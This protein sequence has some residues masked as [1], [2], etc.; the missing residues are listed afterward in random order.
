MIDEWGAL[1]AWRL[2]SA[3]NLR[4]AFVQQG[5]TQYILYGL[6]IFIA[7]L[8]VAFPCSTIVIFFEV[9]SAHVEHQERRVG[10]SVHAGLLGRSR[11]DF[12]AVWL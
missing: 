8:N 9:Q 2:V 1:R 7:L 3:K 4:R 6:G 5:R 10:C 12:E 11:G